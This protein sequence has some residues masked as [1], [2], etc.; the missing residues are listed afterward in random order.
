M[1]AHHDRLLPAAL[2]LEL[3]VR[4]VDYDA[5]REPKTNR[6]CCK[7]QKDIKVGKPFRWVHLVDGG[8]SALHSEDEEAYVK[9]G[10][11]RGDLG[12]HRIGPD[13]ARQ[14]GLEYTHPENWFGEEA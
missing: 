5:R 9:W 13:C 10:G 6:F 4:F 7:C 1:T 12:G 14:V 2:P 3:R 8:Y 11:D